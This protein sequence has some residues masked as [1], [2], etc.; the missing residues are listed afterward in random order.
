MKRRPLG[1]MTGLAL[2]FAALTVL[3]LVGLAFA[4]GNGIF[5]PGPL[6]AQAGTAELKGVHAHADLGGNCGACHATPLSGETMAAK[7]LTC[8]TSVSDELA[9]STGL[10]GRFATSGEC[11][12]C[13]TDH[14]GDTASL[15][16]ANPADFPHERT[17]FALTAHPVKTGGVLGTAFVCADC[18]TKSV[19]HFEAGTCATCHQKLDPPYMAAHLATFGETCRSCHDGVDT[20]GKS[21]DHATWRL[22]GKHATADCAG[23]HQGSHD[24]PALKATATSCAGC[25]TKDDVHQGRLGADCASCHTAEGWD[26]AGEGFDHAKTAFALDGKHTG[27]ECLSCH[28]ERKWTGIGKTCEACHGGAKDPHKGQF[29]QSC[30]SCH[31]TAGWDKVTFDH[32]TTGF[33]LVGA[34]AKPAC[35]DC[36]TGGKYV[37]TPTTCIGC[38]KADDAHK[39]NLG[40][41]CAE[42]HK[43]TTWKDT[44]FHHDQ[45]NFKLTGMHANALCSAC[46]KSM[47]MYR[48]TPTTCFACHKADDVHNGGMGTDCSK[49][50]TT[51]SW[52]GASFDHSKTGFK[53]TGAHTS[54]RC[55][56]CHTK[57]DYANVQTTC[58]GCHRSDDTHGGNLPKCSTCHTTKAWQPDT[59][60]HSSTG[61]KLTG[62]HASASCLK[63]HPGYRYKN[64]PKTCYACHKSQD[65]HNGKFGTSCGACHSTKAWKPA[66]VDHDKT[67]FPLTGAHRSVSCAKCHVNNVYAGTPKTC[68]SC[69]S[70]PSTH[71]PDAFSNC[72]SCHT[73]SRWKPA[74]FNAPHTFPTTHRNAGGVCTKCHP[75]TWASYSCASCHSNSRMDEEHKEVRNYSRTTCAKCHPTGRGD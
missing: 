26:K 55:T 66:S 52:K 6:N 22:E 18:H 35:A 51:K 17:G 40:T 31:T 9:S 25:H 8:H 4:T 61:F 69:H 21:F 75:S 3:V 64:T 70:K 49:C 57:P 54:A 58:I 41:D 67:D 10:H 32:D 63:C 74:D 14:H 11:R 62:A 20:Y 19:A 45:A 30:S 47:T 27:V 59:F 36:H 68:R 7:C 12:T 42:C 50:H 24:L 56:Q 13:H 5:A 15:T 43:V 60:S 34:H 16:L 37:G 73:T 38:H 44:T 46:H 71:Q 48:G 23:C 39:G 2:V 1:C 33:K 72:S 28:V 29:K 53:L 65:A